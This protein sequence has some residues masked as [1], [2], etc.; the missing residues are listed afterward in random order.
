MIELVFTAIIL[1]QADGD[2]ESIW[3]ERIL[4]P[5]PTPALSQVV[6]APPIEKLSQDVCRG[7]GRHHY[8]RNHHR[9]WNCN[10]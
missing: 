3:R 7:K 9:Y 1:A 4:T 8:S 5:P 10:R 6:V 2:F